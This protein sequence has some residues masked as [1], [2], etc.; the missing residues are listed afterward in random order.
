MRKF[1]DVSNDDNRL[2]EICWANE[3]PRNPTGY[4]TMDWYEINTHCIDLRRN[5]EAR[6]HKNV[7]PK[8][9]SF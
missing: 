7:K 5:R 4:V 8:E 9:T 2:F 1:Y 6:E 3:E